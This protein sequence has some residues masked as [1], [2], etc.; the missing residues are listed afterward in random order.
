MKIVFFGAEGWIGKMICDYLEEKGEEVIKTKIRQDDTEEVRRL[1]EEIR[2]TNVIS[3]IGRTHG[4][5]DG[6]LIPTI[7]Y[8]EYPEKLKENVR[9]NLF[10][11]MSCALICKELGIHYTYMGTGC[12]FSYDEN[13]RI[14]D[15]NSLPNFFGSSY[16]TVKGF[17]DR[18]MHQMDNVLNVRIRMPI[19][20]DLAPRSF[21]TKIL[22]YNKICSI[23]NSMTILPELIPVL[24][25]EI[26]N[27]KTGT[28]NLVN[29]G[30][31]EHKEILDMY[32]EIFNKKLEYELISYE[33]QIKML[34]SER[35]NNEL[36]A[37]YIIENYPNVSV[38]KA[39]IRKILINLKKQY[40]ECEKTVAVHI[41][42]GYEH[43]IDEVNRWIDTIINS[44]CQPSFYI[45]ITDKILKNVYD[46]LR[47]I[48]GMKI[49][50]IHNIGLDIGPFFWTLPSM[51]DEKYILKLHTKNNDKLRN[52]LTQFMKDTE[53]FN[54]SLDK[55]YIFGE[56][57]LYSNK[58]I[59]DTELGEVKILPELYQKL[60]YPHNTFFFKQ[61][62]KFLGINVNKKMYYNAG[63][64]FLVE[65]GILDP[66]LKNLEYCQDNI[67]EQNEFSPY[68]FALNNQVPIAN[69]IEYYSNNSHLPKNMYEYPG[70]LNRDGMKEHAWERLFGALMFGCE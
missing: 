69:V 55:L 33:D 28:I 66:I 3:T 36:D 8:L 45:S 63:T 42:I 61:F 60:Y 64:I 25:N 4:Y 27:G 18:L 16:S 1:L 21:I 24:Y 40:D 15:E 29:P 48:K 10:A 17:T 44:N 23:P 2:P 51:K 52:K 5:I 56:K 62:A 26:L 54:K 49:I 50:G 67:T 39:G 57:S 53:T 32:E 20:N 35:S 43:L 7:D 70:C 6:K 9:D 47:K 58:C 11:P 59:W 31:I 68:W 19:S 14:F 38:L 13:D 46:K 12:I 37:R 65:R 34:K 41:H 30:V 22:K